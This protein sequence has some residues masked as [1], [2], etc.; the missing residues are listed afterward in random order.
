[1]FFK[2]SKTLFLEAGLKEPLGQK[3][4]FEPLDWTLSGFQNPYWCAHRISICPSGKMAHILDDYLYDE[5][6]STF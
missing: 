2:H 4:H 6:I 5:V 3:K 1:M